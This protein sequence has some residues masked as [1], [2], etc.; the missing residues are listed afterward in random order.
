MDLLDNI[1]WNTLTGAHARFSI[2]TDVA[3]RYYPGFSPIIGFADPV[4]PD[5]ASLSPFCESG[6]HFYCDR[7]SGPAPEGWF[8]DAESTMFKMVWEGGAIGEDEAL[9][10]VRLGPEHAAQAA[11]LA[12]LTNPGPFGP[13]TLELGDYFGFFDGERLVAMAG[14]R[15]HAG[16]P[17]EISGVCTHPDYQGRG[18]ARRLMF[19]LI[20]RQTARGELPFLHVMRDNSRARAMYARMGFSE[21]RESV[22]RIVCRS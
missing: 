7:W 21:Y 3:R 2:G 14:E 4:R 9:D 19:E 6:E 18:L 1:I 20:R 8:I 12:E 13:R 16:N 10:A 11:S 17:R 22:V 5:F 15:F